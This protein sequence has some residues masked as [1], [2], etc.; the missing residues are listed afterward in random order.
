MDSLNE[1]LETAHEI[2]PQRLQKQLQ[3]ILAAG[4]ELEQVFRVL[5]D[6]LI[7]TNRRLILV[8][9]QGLT[10]KKTEYHSIPYRSITHFSVETAGHVDLDSEL[11]LWFIGEPQP[12]VKRFRKRTD[13]INVQ[14]TL[15]CH[16]LT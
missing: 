1:L 14:K 10:G 9:K 7:F 16:L 8:D 11:K 13:I 3:P 2:K 15:A 5:R 6:L 4:E 12:L